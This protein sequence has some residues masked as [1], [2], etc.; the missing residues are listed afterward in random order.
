M[1]F[2][3]IILLIYSTLGKFCSLFYDQ[4]TFQLLIK[5][6]RIFFTNLY[7]SK[8]KSFGKNSYIYGNFRNIT[9]LEF[10]F[11]GDNCQIRENVRLTAWSKRGEQ[12]FRPEIIIGNNCSIGT[13]S[14]I[15]AI[16]S[17]RLGNNVR[18]GDKIL[19]TDNSHGR[20]T[21]EDLKLPPNERPLFSKGPVVIEDNVWIGEKA[22]I[23]PGVKIGYGS[24]IGAGSVVT[25]DIPAFSMVGG[26]PAKIIKILS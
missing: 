11:V 20:F 21:F 4:K 5:G 14:H 9:G 6:K 17:I 3:K 22:T 12:N 10:I 23:L 13:D 8:F 16:N 2:S 19:I 7:K 25:K 18:M 15:T 24:I 26:K 1:I